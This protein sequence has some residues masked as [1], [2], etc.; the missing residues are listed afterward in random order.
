MTD[1]QAQGRDFLQ[2]HNISFK[3]EYLGYMGDFCPL[4][5]EDG[6]HIHGAKYRVTFRRKDNKTAKKSFSVFFWDSF[7]DQ[8]NGNETVSPY[9]VL[10]AIQK[11]EV[12]TFENF[13]A[14]FGYDADSRKAERIY[15]A[16]TR[17]WYKVGS[18]FTQEELAEAQE[19]Q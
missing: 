8:Q 16:V 17:E 1:Y 3:S 13:C 10:A 18:F 7:N 15:K 9:D 14:D 2:K 11:D 4:W 19:I 5:C 12:G 6:K